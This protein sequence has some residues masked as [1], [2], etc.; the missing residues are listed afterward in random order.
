M[1][2]W[3]AAH[4]CPS[5]PSRSPSPPLPLSSSSHSEPTELEYDFGLLSVQE[6]VKNFM[7]LGDTKSKSLPT[8]TVSQAAHAGIMRWA[9]KRYMSGPAG[10][11]QIR[12]IAGCARV[13]GAHA[14]GSDGQALEASWEREWEREEQNTNE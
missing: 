11:K 7:L 5:P 1:I 14:S 6:Q 12:G 2:V 10:K 9:V 13:L 3:L 4:I 8:P